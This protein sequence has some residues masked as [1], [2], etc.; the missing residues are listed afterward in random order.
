MI[1]FL[2]MDIKIDSFLEEHIFED[3]DFREDRINVRFFWR[4]LKKSIKIKAQRIFRSF[5]YY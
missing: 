4:V 3:D 1:F 5:F 2:K